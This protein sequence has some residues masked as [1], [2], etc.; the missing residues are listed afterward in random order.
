MPKIYSLLKNGRSNCFSHLLDSFVS[1]EQVI[2]ENVLTWQ[3]VEKIIWNWFKLDLT[4]QGHLSFPRLCYCKIH[5]GSFV[6][7]SMEVHSATG[8]SLLAGFEALFGRWQASVPQTCRAFSAVLNV[9]K[10]VE[11][12]YTVSVAFCAWK[13]QLSTRIGFYSRLQSSTCFETTRVS[14]CFLDFSFTVIAVLCSKCFISNNFS[15]QREV[16]VA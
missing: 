13:W 9:T 3:F 15:G 2:C 8:R 16:L 14:R 7:A 12:G 10:V 1:N 5:V 11:K 4:L 6:N